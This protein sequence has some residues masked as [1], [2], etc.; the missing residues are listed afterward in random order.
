[1][2]EIAKMP[3]QYGEAFGRMGVP[4]MGR[5]GA[6]WCGLAPDGVMVFMAHQRYFRKEKD[7][8]FYVD[9]IPSALP[10]ANSA[11][12]TDR[13]MRGYFDAGKREIRLIVGA[14]ETDGDPVHASRF[15]NA[16][17]HYFVAQLEWIKAG[18]LQRAR[19]ISRHDI[20]LP[21]HVWCRE[22]A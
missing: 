2:T 22:A 10:P 11:V 20:P 3:L 6:P 21:G 15:R 14:F 8:Y 4:N 19:V 18:G 5:I 16:P 7:T 17:G 1:L 9:D 13:R 12:E